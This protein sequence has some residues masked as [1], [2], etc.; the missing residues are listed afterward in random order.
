ML[1]VSAVQLLLRRL[2]QSDGGQCLTAYVA[3]RLIIIV[4]FCEIQK[5]HYSS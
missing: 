5:L 3:C 4:S 1:N 2:Y